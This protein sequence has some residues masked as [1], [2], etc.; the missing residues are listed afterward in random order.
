MNAVLL[1]KFKESSLSVLP[2]TIV[3]LA[4]NFVL[5]NPLSAVD[6]TLFF[7]GAALLILGM[8]LYSLGSDTALAPIGESI[9][10]SITATKKIP[11]ILIVGFIIGVIVTIAEPDLM[12]LGSQ[13]GSIKTLIII[14]IALGV[15]LFLVLALA[16]ILSGVNLNVVLIIIY[17]VIFL[18]AFLVD[19][20]YIGL[21]FDSGGVTT[22]PITVPFI[23]ALGVGVA[24]S[25]GGKSKSDNSFGVVAICSAGPI[26]LVL[27][28]SFIFKPEINASVSTE[29]AQTFLE[30]A[31]FIFH[32][33]L[34]SLKDVAIAI[35][36][37]TL[38]F[39]IMNKI[40]IKTPKQRFI[41]ILIGLVY[42]YV[43][44][45]L[46]LTGVNVGFMST[47]YSL[48]ERLAQL[49]N[50]WILIIVGMVIGCFMVLAEPAVH[51]L[52]KQVETISDGNI[53]RSTILISLS[54]SMIVAVGLSML[55]IVYGLSI[56]YILLPGYA[57]AII[58]S[59][60]VPK[61]YTAI[62]FDSGGVASGPMAT[63]FTLPLAIGA[64][65][66]LTGAD[67]VLF[68]AYGLIAFIAL[69]PLIT[70]Q[71]IGVIVRIKQGRK[72]ILPKAFITLFEG[73]IIELD[74]KR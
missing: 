52:S 65:T 54:F 70:I 19:N 13:L 50:N 23:M 56:W 16:R 27:L 40:S 21:S 32:H 59:F 41:R 44:L 5:P 20:E 42:T 35:I 60:F 49:D 47:G 61:I 34:V 33:L 30:I 72:I 53:K 69:T 46:F 11:I 9:G 71:L 1:Q 31:P 18:F 57:L 58:L 36:P 48:G 73:D 12:V 8:V 17:A 25:L 6:L 7:V 66:A 2:I 28:M 63:T 67:S 64:A 55:R 24:G 39:I 10:N 15:G 37:V 74:L 62:A 43:G 45:S 4:L 51:V 68:N 26:L 38:F 29:N 14:A 3:I 22:G